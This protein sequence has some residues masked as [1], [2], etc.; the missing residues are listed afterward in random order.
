M[1]VI[2][3]KGFKT[4][5]FSFAGRQKRELRIGDL[6]VVLFLETEMETALWLLS[7][8]DVK[9]YLLIILGLYIDI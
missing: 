9:K 2:E 6:L 1:P 7:H 4:E 8:F 5:L 3:L